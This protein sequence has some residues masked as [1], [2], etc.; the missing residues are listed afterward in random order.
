M[1]FNIVILQICKYVR[2]SSCVCVVCVCLCSHV[3]ADTALAKILHPLAR[4]YRSMN[5]AEKP[6]RHQT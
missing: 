1:N 4:D 6:L 3:K 2:L 5:Q